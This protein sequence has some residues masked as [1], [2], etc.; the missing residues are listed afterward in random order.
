MTLIDFNQE[1]LFCHLK[2]EFL[3][4]LQKSITT[5]LE[6]PE[7]RKVT[8]GIKRVKISDQPL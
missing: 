7:I 6:L 2:V 1:N 5:F 8:G 4:Q 3:A